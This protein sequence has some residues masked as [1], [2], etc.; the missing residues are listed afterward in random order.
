MKHAQQDSTT[1]SKQVL[2]KK[3]THLEKS[4]CMRDLWANKLQKH[5]VKLSAAGMQLSRCADI[6][7]LHKS[8]LHHAIELPKW[9]TYAG[10]NKSQLQA[11]C[12]SKGSHGLA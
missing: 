9:V 12:V 5:I 2:Y 11:D 6:G 10:K 7:Q 4:D 3:L 1:D 8:C